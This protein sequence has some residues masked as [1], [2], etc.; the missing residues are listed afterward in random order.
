MNFDKATIFTV[1]QMGTVE[2]LKEK[3]GNA[4]PKSFI[5]EKG[6]NLLHCAIRGRN[7]ANFDYLTNTGEIFDSANKDG[8]TPLHY[9]T[10]LIEKDFVFNCVKKLL[11]QGYNINQTN[12]FGNNP[13][14]TAVINCD[15]VDYSLLELMIKYQPP[16][17]QALLAKI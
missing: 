6:E 1:A 17:H 12:K 13:F 4:S 8:E 10:K 5:N 2:Q 15:Y 9:A 14:F 3:I 11:E 7:V 16:L